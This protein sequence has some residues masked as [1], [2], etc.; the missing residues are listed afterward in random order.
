[1]RF[2]LWLG[3]FACLGLCAA[4]WAG[5]TAAGVEPSAGQKTILMTL[6]CVP[7]S[8]W[9]AKRIWSGSD[10]WN[11]D[12]RDFLLLCSFMFPAS[13][14]NFIFSPA[15]APGFVL[16]IPF[17]AMLWAKI[18]TR[19][20][21]SLEE[22]AEGFLTFLCQ[23]A[24]AAL[25]PRVSS[26][27]PLS[28][29]AGLLAV[30]AGYGVMGR[31]R[32]GFLTAF[33]SPLMALWFFLNLSNQLVNSYPSCSKIVLIAG[34]IVYLGLIALG[35]MLAKNQSPWLKTFN[36]AC[37]LIF[38]LSLITEVNLEAGM[39]TPLFLL[40]FHWWIHV[41]PGLD[42][43]YDTMKPYVHYVPFEGFIF[44]TMLPRLWFV[45]LNQTMGGY[46]ALMAGFCFASQALF[47][48]LVYAFLNRVLRATQFSSAL[49]AC[50]IV[51]TN[52]SLIGICYPF[53]GAWTIAERSI[54]CFVCALLFFRLYQ[55]GGGPRFALLVGG[56]HA[57][58][59]FYEPFFGLAGLC[60]LAGV[61]IFSPARMQNKA[62]VAAGIAGVIAAFIIIF[63][64]PLTMFFIH[65][66]FAMLDSGG[67]LVKLGEGRHLF[68]ALF[69]EHTLSIFHYL[70]AL[71]AMLV[72]VG[73]LP[74]KARRHRLFGLALYL[75]IATFF[76]MI[77]GGQRFFGEPD[78]TFS[79]VHFAAMASVLAVP[80]WI[81][82]IRI[83]L[84]SAGL[85]SLDKN[86]LARIC[87]AAAVLAAF[88]DGVHKGLAP[89]PLR[90]GISERRFEA[91]AW[92]DQIHYQAPFSNSVPAI[93]KYYF[94]CKSRPYIANGPAPL[95]VHYEP[96]DRWKDGILPLQPIQDIRAFISHSRMKRE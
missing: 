41:A 43:V 65:Q 84:D 25:A 35:F 78:G 18:F 40:D 48:Y 91:T 94:D 31:G 1:M 87:M 28:L 95:P 26:F 49:L 47:L 42:A 68:M 66:P 6:I 59:F 72:F 24:A 9:A 67:A 60:A 38:A 23:I 20:P 51:I 82:L 55:K 61:M 93:L 7:A 89:G 69:R 46:F 37:L 13:A 83:I 56:V 64:I 11:A 86:A 90:A 73:I 45:G 80:L 5:L 33:L 96:Y 22:M 21:D 74:A 76:M 30:G 92:D 3:N 71:G 12:A 79:T 58:S 29:A 15:Q 34:V 19:E 39:S 70:N 54:I 63:R 75:F 85:K 14:L 8:V 27:W 52:L 32:P 77:S 36:R 44:E 4:Y 10:H 17:M 53:P 81:C 57:F 62:A 50:A 2:A 16:A 88:T